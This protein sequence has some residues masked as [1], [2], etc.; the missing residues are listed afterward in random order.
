LPYHAHTAEVIGLRSLDTDL[1]RERAFI[2]VRWRLDAIH[3]ITSNF[4]IH[5]SDSELG[6][7]FVQ[8]GRPDLP[9]GWGW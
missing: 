6:E 7:N 3:E 2:T 8:K 5:E 1:Y 4:G 9:D